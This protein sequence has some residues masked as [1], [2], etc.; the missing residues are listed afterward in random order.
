MVLR[1]RSA[2]GRGSNGI[3]TVSPCPPG[4]EVLAVNENAVQLFRAGR[5]VGTQFHPEVDPGHV[6]GFLAGSAEEY[7]ASLNLNRTQMM[8]EMYHYEAQNTKQCHRP[9]RL[10]PRPTAALSRRGHGWVRSA[11]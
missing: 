2:Q 1:T 4:A 9:R 10:V 11:S 7:L 3:T 6:A 5:S 8:D